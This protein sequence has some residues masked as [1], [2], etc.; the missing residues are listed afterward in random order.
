VLTNDPC[1]TAADLIAKDGAE[2]S[3]LS[4]QEVSAKAVR[5]LLI[6]AHL[7]GRPSAACALQVQ[8]DFDD[9]RERWLSAYRLAPRFIAD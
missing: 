4:E 9:E 8:P 1:S 3:A 2:L 6:A 5:T 7:D